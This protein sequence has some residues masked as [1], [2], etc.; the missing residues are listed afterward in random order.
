MQIHGDP[1]AKFSLSA[2]DLQAQACLEEV[3]AGY[4]SAWD[5]VMTVERPTLGSPIIF[6]H[7]GEAAFDKLLSQTQILCEDDMRRGSCFVTEAVTEPRMLTFLRMRVIR[8]SDPT[9]PALRKEITLDERLFAVSVDYDGHCKV[10]DSSLLLELASCPEIPDSAIPMTRRADDLTSRATSYAR[11][12]H[13]VLSLQQTVNVVR[14]RNDKLRTRVRSGLKRREAELAERR[15]KMRKKARDK[16][17]KNLELSLAKIRNEQRAIETHLRQRL[18]ELEQEPLLIE[19]DA[20]EPVGTVLLV[21]PSM[22]DG[23]MTRDDAV[24]QVAME[25]AERFERLHGAHVVDVTTPEKAVA[26]G[27][28]PHPGFDLLSLR[29]DGERRAIEVKGRAQE[30]MVQLSANEWAR[31]INERQGFFLYVVFDCATE[32]PTG[33]VVRDPAGCLFDPE[34]AAVRFDAQQIKNAAEVTS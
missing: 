32:A 16:P 6:L 15:N 20:I 33:H 21:P 14:E 27:L 12:V 26:A 31:A 5:R 11:E 25:W 4:P 2:N 23:G 10:E 9:L 19:L 28:T 22:I 3:F 17:T 8:K 34:V 1:T 7:P 18:N 29:P 13:A 30:G 24:E